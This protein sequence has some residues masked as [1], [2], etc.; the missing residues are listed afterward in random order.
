M[1]EHNSAQINQNLENDET[2]D[3]AAAVGPASSQAEREAEPAYRVTLPQMKD[4]LSSFK[5]KMR[6]QQEPCTELDKI[7]TLLKHVRDDKEQIL[8]GHPEMADYF[9][10][11]FV[12]GVARTLA[13]QIK[14]KVTKPEFLVQ[15]RQLPSLLAGIL[16]ASLDNMELCDGLACMFDPKSRLYQYH[17]LSEE[18][19]IL[20]DNPEAQLPAEEREWRRALEV[21]AKLDALKVDPEQKVTCWSQA[22][23]KALLPK[24][25]ILVTFD[26]DSHHC[27]RE[28]SIFSPEL[29]RFAERTKEEQEWR[30]SL[31]PGQRVDCYDST[32]FWY[33]CTIRA[34]EVRQYQ[35]AD[36]DMLHIAF[37][38]S[39]PEGDKTDEEG[40]Q[41]FG[42]DDKFDEWMPRSSSRI[43]RY[44]SRTGGS[45]RDQTSEA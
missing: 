28:L 12:S 20:M 34:T 9:F 2:G 41:F 30:N 29:A 40:N 15:V 18:N 11:D 43:Q 39:H 37:R 10:K 7:L 45:L 14:I 22:T 8:G 33:A 44:E 35:G 16:V 31:Q 17:C 32:G 38:V 1:S 6:V 25:K 36:I 23:L 21:G 13:Q 4:L 42:W 3:P 24:Q 27:D 26:N 19:A 5:A